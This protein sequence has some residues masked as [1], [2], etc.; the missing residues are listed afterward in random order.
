MRTLEEALQPFSGMR[1]P[2]RGLL[3]PSLKR[4]IGTHPHA[5]IGFGTEIEHIREMKPD[6]DYRFRSP[7]RSRQLGKPIGVFRKRLEEVRLAIVIDISRSMMFRVEDSPPYKLWL[8][9]K[10][11][12]SLGR[13]VFE[14]PNEGVIYVANA[15]RPRQLHF[16]T[17]RSSMYGALKKLS[18]GLELTDGAR[19]TLSKTI[20]H[21]SDELPQMPIFVLSDFLI[22]PSKEEAWED[23]SSAYRHAARE[24]SEVIFLRIGDS[25]EHELPG[26]GEIVVDTGRGTIV[27]TRVNEHMQHAIDERLRSITKDAV[28]NTPLNFAEFVWDGDID[29][30]A[31]QFKT[32]LRCRARAAQNRMTSV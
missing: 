6:D 20:R 23:I 3:I 30:L 31:E 22:R 8:A 26:G 7:A 19:V 17:S 28:Y 32:F 18:R 5:K 25:L 29:K 13:M 15:A 21:V 12:A 16:I 10:I 2:F 11:A 1:I 27:S 14:Q 4:D 9:L 24:G